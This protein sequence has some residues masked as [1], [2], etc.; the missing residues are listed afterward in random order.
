MQNKIPQPTF[1]V[2]QCGT[3][4]MEMRNVGSFDSPI[5]VANEIPAEIQLTSLKLQSA[6]TIISLN[7]MV[8]KP[9][10]T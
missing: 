3:R 10:F 7:T 6:S 8:T 5:R 1:V 2:I 4:V 9:T